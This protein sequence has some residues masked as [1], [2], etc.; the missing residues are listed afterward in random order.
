VLQS[1]SSAPRCIALLPL[2]PSALNHSPCLQVH[3][4][5]ERC[6]RPGSQCHCDPH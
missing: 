2:H 3:A 4:A 5:H 1:D 6:Q